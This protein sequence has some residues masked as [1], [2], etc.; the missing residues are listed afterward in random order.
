MAVEEALG[1]AAQNAAELLALPG[2]AD[3]GVQLERVVRAAEV[4]V[5]VAGHEDARRGRTNEAELLEHLQAGHPRHGVIAEDDGELLLDRE[6]QALRGIACDDEIEREVLDRSAERA[7]EHRLVVDV[8]NARAGDRIR[9][10]GSIDRL[11]DRRMHPTVT[12]DYCRRNISKMIGGGGR[13]GKTLGNRE[14]CGCP[15]YNRAVPMRERIELAADAL[16]ARDARVP[17]VIVVLG[18]GLGAF[19]GRLSETVE[20][21]FAEVPGFASSTVPGHDGAVVLGRLE[22][23]QVAALRGRVHLYEGHPPE[24]VVLPVRVLRRSARTSRSSRTRRGA[25]PPSSRRGRCASST[26]T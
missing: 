23:V 8:E 17:Q 1:G 25:C 5:E 6:T 14:K 3:E 15:C 26:T 19:A 21:P 2:L 10:D 11:R 18:S 16:R 4:V 24:T 9:D 22:G 20:V 12:T 13:S 7:Q